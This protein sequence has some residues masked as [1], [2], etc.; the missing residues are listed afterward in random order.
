MD[1]DYTTDEEGYEEDPVEVPAEAP[2]LTVE[3]SRPFHPKS[4]LHYYYAGK[5]RKIRC[6][7]LLQQCRDYLTQDREEFLNMYPESN[8][9]ASEWIQHHIGASPEVNSVTLASLYDMGEEDPGLFWLACPNMGVWTS[10]WRNLAAH[11]VQ[12]ALTAALFTRNLLEFKACFT[13]H[14]KENPL[15]ICLRTKTMLGTL[16]KYQ[17]KMVLFVNNSIEKGNVHDNLMALVRIAVTQQNHLQVL[18]VVCTKQT[19]FTIPEEIKSG[20]HAIV[21]F[22]FHQLIE[23]YKSDFEKELG[24][25][26]SKEVEKVT[27]TYVLSQI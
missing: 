11:K 21:W 12:V 13:N 8:D 3:E 9:E 18:R 7:S 26:P 5:R 14:P 10:T 22:H 2:V 16:R 19:E 23:F 4:T 1:P 27:F 6:H 24:P 25:V 17:E 15:D 20:L